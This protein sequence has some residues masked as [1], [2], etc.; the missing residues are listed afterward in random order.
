MRGE[1]IESEAY[2]LKR[3]RHILG[4]A[5]VEQQNKMESKQ[6]MLKHTDKKVGQKREEA[7]KGRLSRYLQSA[8]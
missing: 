2:P 5:P 3:G 1:R 8:G 6:A 7:T 4:H